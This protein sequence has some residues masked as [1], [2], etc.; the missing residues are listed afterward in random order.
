MNVVMPAAPIPPP[1]E[2]VEGRRF[3][4]YPPILRIDSNEWTYRRATWSEL[5][6]RNVASG[7]ELSIPRRFVGEASESD[8]PDIV[9]S[10][11]E[12]LELRQG[13]VRPQRSR[14]L[15]MPVAA[16][17]QLNETPRPPLDPGHLAPVIGIRLEAK[18][19]S[20]A[21]RVVGGA[22]A[23]GVLGCLALVGYSLQGG[24]AHRRSIITSLDHTYLA[25][26]A[27]DTYSTVIRALGIPDED[28][29]VTTPEGKRL[30]LLA[31]A[32][33]GF[34]AVLMLDGQTE[35]YVGSVSDRGQVL[36]TVLMPNGE[37]SSFLLRCLEDY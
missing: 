16:K 32:D 34:R 23:L 35:R 1:F 25:L 15:Q 10:L 6:V 11:S 24:E 13:V 17:R 28:R 3:S 30:R 37:T 18:H 7:I 19:D 9:V 2:R 8:H 20:R 31:Y 27:A 14:V 29:S 21:S 4:F 36:Q 5:V 26:S 12:Q 22:I 33:R